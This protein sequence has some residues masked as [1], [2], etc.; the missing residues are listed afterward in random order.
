MARRDFS[1]RDR[2]V[3]NLLRPHLNQS[4]QNAVVVSSLRDEL[5]MV[6][7][8]LEHVDAGLSCSTGMTGRA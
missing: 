4:Y 5:A 1:E 6:E 7:R 3:L 2:L 8:G